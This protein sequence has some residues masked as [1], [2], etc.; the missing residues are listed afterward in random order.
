MDLSAAVDRFLETLAAGSSAHTVRSYASDLRQLVSV[1]GKLSAEN[2]QESSIREF[3][4]KYGATPRTRAR[5]LCAVRA[6]SK[7][8]IEVGVL[9]ADPAIGIEAPI[10]RT[11]LPKDLSPEQADALVSLEMGAT[12]LRDQAVL[13]LLYGAGLRASE[14]VGV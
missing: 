7:F 13:E 8:L 10:K 5:K 12:P 9:A 11:R 1:V 3:L 2:L 6:F 4:R 14:V